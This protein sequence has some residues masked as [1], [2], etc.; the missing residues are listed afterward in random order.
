[1]NRRHI[2]TLSRRNDERGFGFIT[3]HVGEDDIFVHISSFNGE[4]RP[5]IG[6][7]LSY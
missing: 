7:I 5:S 3:P 4:E 6:Q 1:M 2:G